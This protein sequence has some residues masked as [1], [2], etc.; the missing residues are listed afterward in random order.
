VDRYVI[1]FPE[2]QILVTSNVTANHNKRGATSG[3]QQNYSLL[4]FLLYLRYNLLY[5]IYVIARKKQ[6][7]PAVTHHAIKA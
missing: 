1:F 2:T 5:H 6:G 3:N 7:L 4:I